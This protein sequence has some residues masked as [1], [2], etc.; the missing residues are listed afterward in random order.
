MHIQSARIFNQYRHFSSKETIDQQFFCM[1]VLP[2]NMRP[3]LDILSDTED[4]I[5]T[6]LF[7]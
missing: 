5:R 3:H 7:V 2:E 1:H 6:R 4:N